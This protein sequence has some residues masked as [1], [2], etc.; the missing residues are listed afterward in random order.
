MEDNPNFLNLL[1]VDLCEAHFHL[2][3]KVNSM[4]NVFWGQEKPFE[5]AVKPL[6]SAKCT[7]WTA[8][9]KKMV[10]LSQLQRNAMWGSWKTSK[11]SDRPSI[12]LS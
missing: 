8:I 2:E 1:H 12:Q 11:R 4:N 6:Y 7:F 3:G 5:V 10:P 9:R